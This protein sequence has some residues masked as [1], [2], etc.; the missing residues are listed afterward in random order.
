MTTL[1]LREGVIHSATHPFATAIAVD[2]G[3]ISWLG[4]ADTAD[5]LAPDMDGVTDL[6]GALVT[7]TLMNLTLPGSAPV[8]QPGVRAQPL[9][10]PDRVLDARAD[11]AEASEAIAQIRAE[12]A[13]D[14]ES[15]VRRRRLVLI[16]HEGPDPAELDGL[17][18][19]GVTV[20]VTADPQC[21]TPLLA[22]LAAMARAGVPFVL[23]TE[24]G[25]SPWNTIRSALRS[26]HGQGI[27]ARAAFRAHTRAVWRL[28]GSEEA[29]ELRIGAPA[30]ISW[31]R[32]AHLGVDVPDNGT[33]AGRG[34]ITWSQDARSGTP[35]LPILDSDGADPVCEGF[36]HV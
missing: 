19:W 36:R 16:V 31:W 13:H 26:P 10:D 3:V 21:A 14:G 32:A 33:A 30:E 17:A 27:T 8:S 5:R 25:R 29:G 24:P 2:D 1:L 4:D 28:G 6:A 23:T 7:P 12:A 18:R 22:P 20:V 9:S 11:G 15:A 34:G 35:L